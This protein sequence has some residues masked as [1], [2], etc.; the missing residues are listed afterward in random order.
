MNHYKMTSWE[1]KKNF[2]ANKF[3]TKIAWLDYANNLYCVV[4]SNELFYSLTFMT[5]M[6]IHKKSES[7]S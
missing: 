3:K 2:W 6:L 1:K 4:T 5:T 7:F